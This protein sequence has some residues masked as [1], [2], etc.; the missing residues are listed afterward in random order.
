MDIIAAVQYFIWAGQY[1]KIS[2]FNKENNIIIH[3]VEILMM[4]DML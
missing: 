1:S 2:P 4:S 3:V